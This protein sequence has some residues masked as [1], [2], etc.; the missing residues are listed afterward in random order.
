MKTPFIT[1]TAAALL[2]TAC[3]TAPDYDATGIFEATTVTLSAETAGRILSFPVSEGDSVL[4]GQD[5]KSV[6]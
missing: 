6:V 4:A 3:N 2:A 5:R 1:I